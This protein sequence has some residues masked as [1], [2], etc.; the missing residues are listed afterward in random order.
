MG[1]AAGHHEST[2]LPSAIGMYSCGKEIHFSPGTKCGAAANH[3]LHN[4]GNLTLLTAKLIP[5]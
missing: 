3:L 4:I 2:Q 5:L 1:S